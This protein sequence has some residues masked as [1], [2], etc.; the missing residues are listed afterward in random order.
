VD[1]ETAR[2]TALPLIG[3]GLLTGRAVATLPMWTS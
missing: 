3:S 2:R 1:Q